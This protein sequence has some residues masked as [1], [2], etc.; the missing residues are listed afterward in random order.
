MEPAFLPIKQANG[1]YTNATLAQWTL[2]RKCKAGKH[3]ESFN[4]GVFS[5]MMPMMR[6][7]WTCT[8]HR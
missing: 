6:S 4:E 7:N 3:I 5:G 2:F 8:S 1:A